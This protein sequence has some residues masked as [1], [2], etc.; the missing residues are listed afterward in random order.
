MKSL[1]LNGDWTLVHFAEGDHTAAS[2]EA[3]Q[4]LKLPE[5]Q[6]SVPGNVELDLVRAGQL[7]EPYYGA[8]IRLLRPLETHE[9]WYRR[10]FRVPES[11]VKPG[12]VMVFEGLDTLAT[13]WLNGVM[14]GQSDN[15]LIEQRF[16]AGD[17]LR[18]GAENELVVRIASALNYARS[19]TYDASGMSWER[20]EEGLYIRKAPHVWGWD[21]LPRAV[22]AGIWRPVRLEETP[23]TAIDQLYF[24]T[25]SAEPGMSLD[26]GS[27]VLGVRFQFR[28]PERD[29][30]GFSLRFHGKCGADGHTFDYE[31]PAEFIA[32]GC[33]IPIAGARLWWPK[34]YG[35]PDLYQVTTELLHNGNMVASRVDQVGLRKL[36]VDRTELAGR[37]HRLEP[38]PSDLARMDVL[39]DPDSHFIFSV[40]GE[41]VQIRG[42][43]WVPLDAFHSRDAGRLEQAI[44][45]VDDLG[46]NMVRCWGGNV[47]ESDRFYQLC[48]EKGI[49]IWQDFAF[50]C[51]RYPQT[52]EFLER[53]RIEVEA[54]VKRLRNQAALAIWCGD[55]EIDMAYL[56][57]GLSP[58]GNRLTRD[59]IPSVL[60]RLDPFRAYVPSSPYTPPAVFQQR[61]PWRATPEQHLWGPRNYYK[62]SFYIQHSAHFIGEIGYHGSPGADSIRKFIS[63]EQVWPWQNNEEWQIHSVYHW[64]TRAVERD[65][66]QLM[67]NQVKELFGFI[68]EDLDA[69]T[70]AS[71]ITQAEAKKFFI[72]LNSRAE[73]VNQRYFVVECVG[74]LAAV[75]GCGCG[76]L[77]RQEI[78]L[79]LYLAVAASRAGDAG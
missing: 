28:T 52:A 4:S 45:L 14:I 44:A 33:T 54:V 18:V 66:I 34:G 67:A 2:P 25:I 58:E 73:V 8:N 59:V 17:A 50:A 10:T 51:S 64:Q 40:N 78:G 63:P 15:M 29:L 30:D 23:E 77:L 43:N 42:T 35:R 13:V 75:F 65:R 53:V 6:A 74:W 79:P 56:S 12:S 32:G 46:C 70:L 71:Q 48:A 69:F 9:W 26:G 47:Y 3:L 76:L 16:D 62:S 60:Q 21:I 20:R 27:A 11:W 68:P 19:L 22:S 36:V 39:P 61:D 57:D 49:L 31:W 1:S 72:E 5:I 38:F 55:N 37:P 24:Y 7:P 41:P